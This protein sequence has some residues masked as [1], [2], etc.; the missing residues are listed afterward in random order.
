MWCLFLI[1]SAVDKLER[2]RGS[3]FVAHGVVGCG[4]VVDCE[5]DGVD[6]F[7][8]GNR[9]CVGVERGECPRKHFLA[10]AVHHERFDLL[11]G[12][13][14]VAGRIL[15]FRLCWTEVDIALVS[16]CSAVVLVVAIF[17]DVEVAVLQACR[18]E[19]LVD[20]LIYPGDS[21]NGIRN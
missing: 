14:L 1:P 5:I 8:S 6:H 11:V 12:H 10:E 13:S 4:I 15:L 17:G 2:A 9:R 21:G 3:H 20:V 7:E 16:R 19:R 18:S